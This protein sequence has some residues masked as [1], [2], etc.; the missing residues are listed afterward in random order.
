MTSMY[1]HVIVVT[2]EVFLSLFLRHL[3]PPEKKNG[4]I[5]WFLPPPSIGCYSIWYAL[6]PHTIPY[7]YKCK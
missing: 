3:T 1:W 5:Q 2:L 6:S 7:I 4:M